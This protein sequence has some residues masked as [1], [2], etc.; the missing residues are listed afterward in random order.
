VGASATTGS[1]DPGGGAAKF[2][3]P[4][5]TAAGAFSEG[6]RRWRVGAWPPFFG[7][8]GGEGFA[9]ESESGFSAGVEFAFAFEGTGWNGGIG[10]GVDPPDDGPGAGAGETSGSSGGLS[11]FVLAS[12][13]GGSG[14]ETV[15]ASGDGAGAAGSRGS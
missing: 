3:T 13:I 5:A 11:G 14:S 10:D 15:G 8:A 1:N 6:G 9:E 7:V 4:E 12:L 2:G